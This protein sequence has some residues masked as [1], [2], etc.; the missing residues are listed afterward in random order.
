MRLRRNDYTLW[1]IVALDCAATCGDD[2]WLVGFYCFYA[3]RGKELVL[4]VDLTGKAKKERPE[5]QECSK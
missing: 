1:K 4:V 2:A 5:V 3:V